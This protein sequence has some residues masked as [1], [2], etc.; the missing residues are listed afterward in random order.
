MVN[1]TMVNADHIFFSPGQAAS[2]DA[3]RLSGTSLVNG[4]RDTKLTFLDGSVIVLK[5]VSRVEAVFPP[6]GV[7]DQS[8]RQLA[9]R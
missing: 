7:P 2:G 6:D 9:A 1:G 8:R 5:G 3:R 4:G